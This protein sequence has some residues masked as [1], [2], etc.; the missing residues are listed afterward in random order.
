MLV[1]VSS[2]H[3]QAALPPANPLPCSIGYC[4]VE[5]PPMYKTTNTPKGA[6]AGEKCVTSYEEFVK[7]PLIN[8]YWT[9]DEPTTTQGKANERARQFLYW[10]LTK[11]AI[12]QHPVIRQIWTV[13]QN[14]TLFLF[15]LVAALFGL[16]YIVGQRSD[17]QLKMQIWPI[18]Y[19]IGAGLLYIVFS[20]AIIMTFIQLSEVIMNF[21]IKSLGGDRLFNI[22]FAGKESKEASYATFVGCRDLNYKVQEAIKA[23]MYLMKVT[24]VTYYAMGIMMLLRKILLWFLLFAAPF[25]ALLM[26]FVFIRNVGW[27]WIGT[28]AQWVFYGP[29]FALFLGA[30]TKIWQSG[31]PFP[32]DFSRTSSVS[33]YI[34]PTGINIVYGGPA[35]VGSH[36][37]STLNNGNYIDTFAEYVIS[38]IMLWAVI[39]FPWFLL[40]IFRD[41]CCDG[42]M[43]MKN[44]LMSMYDRL[45]P[46]PKTPPP[47]PSA[48]HSFNNTSMKMNR[49]V[50]VP[51]KVKLETLQEIKQTKTEDITKSLNLSMNKITDIAKFETNKQTNE[52]VRKNI[53]MLSQP[54]KA[55]TPAERQKFMNIR[56]ELFNRTIKEDKVARQILSSISSSRTESSTRKEELLRTVPRTAPPTAYKVNISTDKVT[57]MNTSLVNAVTSNTS[58]LAQIAQTTQAPAQQIQTVLSSY[59]TNIAHA[60]AEILTNITKET[61]IAS[62]TVKSIIKAI[63]SSIKKNKEVVK[64]VAEKEQ[65]KEE[66]VERVIETQTPLVSEPEKTIEQLVS[67]PPSVSIEDYEEV[68]KMWTQ[69][70]EK[71]EVPTS[72]NITS[73][74]QWVDQDVVFITNTL[75]K[76][77][78][79]DDKLRQEGIDDLAY[80][81]PIFLINSLKG[82]ELIVYL[83]AKIEA[84]KAVKHDMDKER[85]ITEKLKKK[86][87]ETEEFVDVKKKTEENTKTLEMSQ[88]LP[89]E[90]EKTKE[91]SNPSENVST[92]QSPPEEKL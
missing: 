88:D 55:G 7:D 25:L 33:G 77:L 76:L 2:V 38:L 27:I 83:K 81:L 32:F 22:Y 11:S 84:A 29:L 48:S 15:L 23:E 1:L 36:M 66:D 37:I 89:G 61:G 41:Y 87:E 8:H 50:E 34:Y 45:A 24:N 43:A 21:F 80:I 31:I 35:Q 4:P 56:T 3:A 53:D 62:D 90:E 14:I 68:K 85:E 79:A 10:V 74:E 9:L 26:P 72:E 40:R 18:I 39:I 70:Y 49:E 78:S 5:I 28:F 42:I 54:T 71:G 20:Y 65:M 52:T 57:S 75:N 30:L 13:T 44:V 67:I 51:I 92:P 6:Y 19:K 58:V 63:A 73:R 64:K 16:G 69:Q 12:D 59:K 60:P 46:P 86:S 47:A 82:E 17:F 91:E